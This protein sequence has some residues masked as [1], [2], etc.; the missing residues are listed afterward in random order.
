[1][2]TVV[3]LAVFVGLGLMIVGVQAVAIIRDS[4][5]WVIAR[6]IASGKRAR[7]GRFMRGVRRG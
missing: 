2:S 6:G 4:D 5:W 1:M 3:A 7:L